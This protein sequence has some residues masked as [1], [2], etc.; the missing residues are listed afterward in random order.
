VNECLLSFG[1]ESFVFQYAIQKYKDQDT[2]NYNL[3][4]VSYGCETGSLALR[5]EHGQI[6]FEN[7]ALRKIRGPRRDQVIG[8]WRGLLKEELYDLKSSVSLYYSYR[9]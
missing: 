6:V 8:K 1:A 3:A 7:R 4:G 5:E 9:A 2:E